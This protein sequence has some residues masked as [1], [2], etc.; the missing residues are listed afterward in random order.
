[1]KT[2]IAKLLLS[3]FNTYLTV[4][5]CILMLLGVV[6]C[7]GVISYSSISG[8]E[9]SSVLPVLDRFLSLKTDFV[10]NM[11]QKNRSIKVRFFPSNS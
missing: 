5:T 7:H 6:V 3:I 2:S 4:N 1:M 11:K 10:R 8:L 9:K